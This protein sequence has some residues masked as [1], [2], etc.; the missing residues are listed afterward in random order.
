MARMST[1]KDS[2]QDYKTPRNLIEAIEVRFG[3]IS[4]D[5]AADFSNK[6]ADLYFCEPNGDIRDLM[7][8]SSKEKGDGLLAVDCLSQ[9]WVWWQTQHPGLFFDNP[10]FKK[11]PEFSCKH[12]EEMVRGCSSLLLIPDDATRAYV[13][14]VLGHADIYRLVGRVPF[15]VDPV[16]GNKEVFPKDCAICHFYPGNDSPKYCFWDWRNNKILHE[17][18][19]E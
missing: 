14:N 19:I 18:R 6:V 16:T 10:P 13:N 17:F 1:G 8:I 4:V 9:D 2:K 3:K 12:K 7:G 11:I 5:V 15:K